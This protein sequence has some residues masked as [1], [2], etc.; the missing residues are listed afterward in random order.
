MTSNT[1]PNGS[2]GCPAHADLSV[3]VIGGGIVGL[4]TA[5]GLLGRGYSVTVYE[6]AP[7]LH[8]VGAAFAFTGVAREAMRQL[9]ARV[10]AALSRVGEAN[11]HPHN[12]YWDGFRP[13]TKDHAASEAESLLFRMSARELD[14]WGC[15]RQALLQE[16]AAEVPAGVVQFSKQLADC[17]DEPGADRVLLRFADGT[18]AKVDAG[19]FT[20]T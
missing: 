8:E 15:L 2:K 5:L 11:R 16:L 6:R 12:R 3:A 17:V 13:K 18:T 20:M 1:D 14:Y 10:L 19:L 9:D 4:M 7:A